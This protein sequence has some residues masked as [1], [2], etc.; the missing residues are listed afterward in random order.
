MSELIFFLRFFSQYKNQLLLTL[1]LNMICALSSISLLTLAGWFITAAAIAGI[2]AVDHVAVGFNFMQPAAEIRALAISRTA[3]R[4]FERLS[5]HDAT[6]KGM[7]QIRCWFFKQVIPLAPGTLETQQNADLLNNMTNDINRLDSLYIN[8]LIPFF[9]AILLILTVSGFI[10]V[11]SPLFSLLILLQILL[12]IFIIPLMIKKRFQSEIKNIVPVISEIKSKQLE[13]T[14]AMAEIKVYAVETI[15]KQGLIQASGKL[16]DHQK[17]LSQATALNSAAGLFLSVLSLVFSLIFSAELMKNTQIT[18]PE[19]IM[20]VFLILAVF[21]WL[22]PLSQTIQQLPLTQASAK[23]VKHISTLKPSIIDPTKTTILPEQFSI[24]LNHVSF[25]YDKHSPWLL[26]NINLDIQP[27]E[28]IALIGPSGSGKTSLIQLI[29][30]F[31]SPEQGQLLYGIDKA[32]DFSRHQVFKQFS[33]L[34]QK[35]CLF[36]ESLKKN[37]LKAKPDATDAELI[38]ALKQTGLTEFLTNLPKG[39]NSWLGENGTRVS[40]G[41]ARR[42]ALARV[43]LK[44][45]PVLILDE[46]TEGLDQQTE[47][48]LFKVLKEFSQDKTLIL[49]SHKKHGLELVDKVYQLNQTRLAL[50]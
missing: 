28:K 31:Y 27:G 23:R 47:I 4:Y 48:R 3:S 32:E 38:Q 8:L 50:A 19:V 29:M 7:K 35:T 11:Y 9:V 10:A 45:S 30:R 46:P 42:I 15:F 33:L 14:Q 39:L 22:M 12:C 6:F 5:A 16:I 36:S 25:R 21:E 24:Q 34:S 26:K 49:V 44:N 1:A 18:G 40:V 43:I 2:Q 17:K 20:L 41:E 37:L 13:L